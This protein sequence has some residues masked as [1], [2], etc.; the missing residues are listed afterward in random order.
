[1]SNIIKYKPKS[2]SLPIDIFSNPICYGINWIEFVKC[3]EICDSK[4]HKTKDC[5]YCL[6]CKEMYPSIQELN[7][8]LFSQLHKN[9]IDE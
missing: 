3:C 4:C 6:I 8:H 9:K 5:T 1:M 2:K 7:I